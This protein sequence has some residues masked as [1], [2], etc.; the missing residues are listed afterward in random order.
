MRIKL[1]L[2][3]YDFDIVHIKGV[4]NIQADAL[5]RIPFSTIKELSETGEKVTTRSMMKNNEMRERSEVKETTNERD[6]NIYDKLNGY[7][8]KLC[9]HC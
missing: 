1:E 5:S 6:I 9:R 2:E 4:E 7:S 8:K 3:E